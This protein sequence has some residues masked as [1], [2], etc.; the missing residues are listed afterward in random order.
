MIETSTN[1]RIIIV[2]GVPRSGTS[3]CMQILQAGGIPVLQDEKFRSDVHNPHGYLEWDD[4]KD[5]ACKP[6]LIEKARGKCLKIVSQWMPHLPVFPVSQF[7]QYEF[8]YK[9]IFIERDMG[10]CIASQYKFARTKFGLYINAWADAADQRAVAAAYNAHIRDIKMMLIG[11][12]DVDQ[13]FLNYS[14]FTTGDKDTTLRACSKIFAHV[15]HDPQDGK[16]VLD[17]VDIAL[18]RNRCR[19]T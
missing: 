5:L 16:K 18:Y 6:E 7:T 3:M 17:A 4:V 1:N 15:E 13:L 9:V 12:R 19:R 11:R 10:E 8:R 14:E 2:S